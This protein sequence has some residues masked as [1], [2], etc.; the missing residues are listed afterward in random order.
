MA[1]I[2]PSMPY[3]LIQCVPGVSLVRLAGQLLAFL[4][5][6]THSGRAEMHA[7]PS[8][9]QQRRPPGSMFAVWLVVV[10]SHRADRSLPPSMTAAV[11]SILAAS[12]RAQAVLVLAEEERVVSFISKFQPAPCCLL[13]SCWSIVQNV[14][15]TCCV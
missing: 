12:Q 3:V 1:R 8:H 4:P 11:E 14:C 7:Q 9:N 6:P 15:K 13:S 10:G 2:N 5:L